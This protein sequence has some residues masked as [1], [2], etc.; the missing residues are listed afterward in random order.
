MGEPLANIEVY[1]I[2]ACD[3]VAEV[4]VWMSESVQELKPVLREATPRSKDAYVAAMQKQQDA[5]CTKWKQT[6][7]R[8]VLAWIGSAFRA[9]AA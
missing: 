3:V 6:R 2:F 9:R 1:A 8:V 7:R 4:F 5:L